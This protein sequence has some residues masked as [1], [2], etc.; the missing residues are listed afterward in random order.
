[1]VNANDAM[2]ASRRH[3]SAG[4][5]FGNAR[6]CAKKKDFE[7][8]TRRGKVTR[9]KVRAVEIVREAPAIEQSARQRDTDTV[10]EDQEFAE[11]LAPPRWSWQC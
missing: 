1:M 8:A 3:E 5:A 7:S 4:R 11:F 10:I 2:A 6:L 9:H